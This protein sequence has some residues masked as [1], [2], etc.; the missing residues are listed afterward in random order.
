MLYLYINFKYILT[1]QENFIL[2]Q[3]KNMVNIQP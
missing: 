1:W 3:M 2:N